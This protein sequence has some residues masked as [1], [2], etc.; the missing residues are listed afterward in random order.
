MT[1][2]NLEPKE[3]KPYTSPQKPKKENDLQSQTQTGTGSTYDG[4]GSS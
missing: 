2:E 1:D 4:P 3:K